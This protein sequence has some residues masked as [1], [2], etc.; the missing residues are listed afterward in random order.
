MIEND[1]QYQVTI[2]QANKIADAL[3]DMHVIGSDLFSSILIKA[4]SNALASILIELTDDIKQYE[5]K[6][7]IIK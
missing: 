4:E 6:N 1:K 3:I 7:G 5:V 2:M